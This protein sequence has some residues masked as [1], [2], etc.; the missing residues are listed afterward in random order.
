MPVYSSITNLPDGSVWA[1][2]LV[3]NDSINIKHSFADVLPDVIKANAWI[4]KKTL[5]YWKDK[6]NDFVLQREKAILTYQNPHPEY[7]KAITKLK[8]LGRLERQEWA[9]KILASE[10]DIKILL[11]RENSP[12]K[13]WPFYIS[14]IFDYCRATVGLKKQNLIN[15]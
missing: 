10:A 5:A 8:G 11:P 12:I 14:E 2:V 4:R 7:L 1:C 9:L 15:N 6:L 3:K 13:C